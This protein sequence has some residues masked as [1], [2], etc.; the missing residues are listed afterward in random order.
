MPGNTATSLYD[1]NMVKKRVLTFSFLISVVFFGLLFQTAE[2]INSFDALNG[3]LFQEAVSKFNPS[4][5]E[6]V[7]I[8]FNS[9]GWGDTPVEEAEDF[10]SVV[11]G[12]QATLRE[13]GYSAVVVPY[14]RTKDNF[15]GRVEG[16][17]EVVSSFQIQSKELAQQIESFLENNPGTKVVMTGLSMGGTFVAETMKQLPPDFEVYAIEA[18]V[19]F[20]VERLNSENILR[21]DNGQKDAL[22]TGRIKT[23]IV[24]LIKAPAIWFT[25]KIRGENLTFAQAIAAPGHKYQ[26]SSPEVGPKIVS[27]LKSRLAQ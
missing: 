15:L 12:I 1:E 5:Q 7:L 20:W 6:R 26:W 17:K 10:V 11:K 21:L 16:V 8:V 23:L 22:A 4:S 13:W 25:A 18:G 9:G 24:A 2:G 19:P 27:F 14:N 3:N